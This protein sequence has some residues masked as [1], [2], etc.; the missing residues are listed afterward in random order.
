MKINK[1]FWFVNDIFK[2]WDNVVSKIII[3]EVLIGQL[4]IML[5]IYWQEIV[6]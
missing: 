1:I 5:K 6:K 2:I 3:N 4:R